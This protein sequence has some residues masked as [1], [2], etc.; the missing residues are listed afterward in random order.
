LL[1]D[2]LGDLLGDS[3]GHRPGDIL[4]HPAERWRIFKQL[5]HLLILLLQPLSILTLQPPTG[6]DVT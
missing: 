1:S 3:P 6:Y 5:K 4:F 2:L